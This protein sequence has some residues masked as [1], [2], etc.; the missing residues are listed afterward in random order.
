MRHAESVHNRYNSD[1]IC[2]RSNDVKL[3]DDG[4]EQAKRLGE[5][6]RVSDIKFDGIFSSTAYR[7]METG[8]LAGL[9]IDLENLYDE[10]LEMDQGEWEGKLRKDIYTNEMMDKMRGDNWHFRAPGG[11]SQYMVENRMVKWL[12]EHILGKYSEGRFLVITHSMA[13]GC[14]LR[15]I[16]DTDARDTYKHGLKNT[17]IT[18]I[19]YIGDGF[20]VI[21]MNNTDHLFGKED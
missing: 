16:R 20:E 19:R 14:L 3:S 4:I 8:Y 11:E 21:E 12:E 13:I 15:Y 6:L 5:Y 9:D 18:K 17:S 2:G 10:L 1:V 7:T